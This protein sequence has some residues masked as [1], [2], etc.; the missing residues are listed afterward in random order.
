ML[1]ED[2]LP[3]HGRYTFVFI[4]ASSAVFF[5]RI[6]TSTP[7]FILLLFTLHLL[8]IN[9]FFLKPH[10]SKKKLSCSLPVLVLFA[11]NLK[12]GAHLASSCSGNSPANLLSPV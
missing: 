11:V 7:F 12:K 8:K 2:G 3:M 4:P 10:L 1:W 6:K 5:I 9:F